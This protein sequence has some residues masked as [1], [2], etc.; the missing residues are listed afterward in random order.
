MNTKEIQDGLW[1]IAGKFDAGC[2]ISIDDDGIGVEGY[3]RRSWEEKDEHVLVMRTYARPFSYDEND[4][5]VDVIAALVAEIDKDKGG[6]ESPEV[7]VDRCQTVLKTG[8]D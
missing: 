2:Q 8:I 5:E 3:D 7:P 1:V 4:E 6:G